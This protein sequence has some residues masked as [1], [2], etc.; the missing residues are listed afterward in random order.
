LPFGNKLVKAKIAG[1]DL[2]AALENSLWFAG[3]PSGRFAQVSGLR[4]RARADSRPGQ[5][6]QSVE[7]DGVPLDAD[8]AYTVATNDFILRG[9]DGYAAFTRAE[10]VIGAADGDLLAG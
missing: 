9:Q 4:V 3:R 5:R 8:R 6:I 10:T 1:R 7:I 2:L